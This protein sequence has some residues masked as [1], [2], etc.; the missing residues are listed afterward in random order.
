M[1]KAQIEKEVVVNKHIGAR[2]RKRRI[3]DPS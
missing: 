1:A 2:I 3:E